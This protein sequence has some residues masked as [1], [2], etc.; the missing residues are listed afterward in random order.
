MG[1]KTKSVV[2]M[3]AALIAFAAVAGTT[4]A[5]ERKSTGK[6]VVEK[7]MTLGFP[8]PG[9][10]AG[11]IGVKKVKVALPAAVGGDQAPNGAARQAKRK[12][13]RFCKRQIKRG[14]V[15]VYHVPDDG[16]RSLLGTDIP[17]SDNA[18]S[19]SGP[20]VPTEDV[21][22]ADQNP[23]AT[24]IRTGDYRWKVV[25]DRGRAIQLVP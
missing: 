15:S 5:R 23:G 19:V 2:V 11:T 3:L 17:G 8:S 4:G 9:V 7:R 18:Y 20:T 12:A 22:S 21:V 6:I 1:R 24:G 13:K 14:Q 16:P 10:Y 25:C